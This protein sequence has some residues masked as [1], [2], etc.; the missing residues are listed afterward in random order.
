M[1]LGASFTSN[2]M[3]VTV[4][5]GARMTFAYLDA[6]PMWNLTKGIHTRVYTSREAGNCDG[7]YR[8]TISTRLFCGL[9]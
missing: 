4:P 5:N 7:P 6:I 1:K 3:R 2:P 9:R 8:M